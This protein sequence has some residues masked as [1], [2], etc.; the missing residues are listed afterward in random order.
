MPQRLRSLAL[1]KELENY[2]ALTEQVLD[3]ARRRV[4]VGESVPNAEK[5]FSIFEPHTEL[6]QRGKTPQPV[7]FGHNLLVLEDTVGFVVHYEVL[8]KG[9]LDKDAGVPALKQAQGKMGGKIRSASFDRSFH[10]PANQQALA[11]L[12]DY[13]CV[14]MRGAKQAAQQQASASVE[15]RAGRRH[16]PGVESAIHALQAGNGLE[17]CRDRTALGYERYVGLGILGRNLHILGKVVLAQEGEGCV[18]SA[19]RRKQLPRS[20]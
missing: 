20:A 1:G 13:P 10:T 9:V 11:E 5:L 8:A 16:H 19:S 3:Q 4:V 18:A 12:V 17:R 7:E 2:V 6:I 14:P 15:F